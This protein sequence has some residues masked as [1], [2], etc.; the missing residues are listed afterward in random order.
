MEESILEIS[1]ILNNFNLTEIS[2]VLADQILGPEAELDND[3]PINYFDILYSKYKNIVEKEI[4]DDDSKLIIE[5][6]FNEIC[7]IFIDVLSKKF[8]F[9]LSDEYVSENSANL[10]PVTT[11]LY[12]FF[13]IDYKAIVTNIL[14]NYI[15]RHYKEIYTLF[16]NLKSRKDAST[17]ANKKILTPEYAVIVSNIHMITEWIMDNLETF[18]DLLNYMDKKYIFYPF[19]KKLYED[20]HINGQI[21]YMYNSVFKKSLTLK[22]EISFDILSAI[23]YKIASPVIN[24]DNEE[25]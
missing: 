4:S 16:D 5:N 3:R 14:T 1:D 7:K 23:K 6:R 9:E 22:G 18:E 17:L 21:A 8:R 25:E 19:I 20:G 13:I 11:A 24:N 10:I 15:E 2:N 12:Y